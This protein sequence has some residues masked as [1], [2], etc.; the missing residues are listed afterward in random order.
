MKN[1]YPSGPIAQHKRLAMGL[2]VNQKVQKGSVKV[3][4]P[5]PMKGGLAKKEGG[6]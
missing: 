6:Y 5:K 4:S 2:P 1:T 3:P